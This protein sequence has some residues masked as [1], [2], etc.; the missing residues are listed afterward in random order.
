MSSYI[1]SC[2]GIGERMAVGVV[3][4]AG[5]SWLISRP[6]EKNFVL[7][8]GVLGGRDTWR[9]APYAPIDEPVNRMRPGRRRY[10]RR[11]P[12]H[13][14]RPLRAQRPVGPAGG[15][16]LDTRGEAEALR[17]VGVPAGP[18]GLAAPLD[19]LKLVHGAVEI[20]GGRGGGGRPDFAQGG[21][22]KGEKARTAIAGIRE[23]L[24]LQAQGV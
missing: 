5:I 1:A 6:V 4:L 7:V 15:E 24:A 20:L 3:S 2:T 23:M 12:H 21:G 17:A 22:P 16:G 10:V 13:R 14:N 8:V 11:S 18:K 9:V 19:A